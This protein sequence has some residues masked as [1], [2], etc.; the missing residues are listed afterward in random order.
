M[1]LMKTLWAVLILCLFFGSCK[2]QKKYMEKFYWSPTECSPE[3][4]PTNLVGGYF[5]FKDG[6]HIGMSGMDPIKNGWGRDGSNDAIGDG[7]NPIPVKLE[8]TWL[9][10][11]EN[12]FFSGSF[13][14]PSDTLL[15]LFQ[16]GYKDSHTL[17]QETYLGIDVGMAPG[18]VVVV[19]LQG[20]V[21]Q[22][23]IGRYQAK[24]LDLS[25]ADYISIK[26]Y[27]PY[28]TQDRAAL[29]KS[30]IENDTAVLENLAKKG[31]QFGLWD[32]YRKCFN[33]RPLMVYD[34]LNKIETSEIYMQFF[35][36]EK[37][38]L[39]EE[40]LQKNDY[41]SYARIKNIEVSF[42][43]DWAGKHQKYLAR[44]AFNEAEMFEVY[45]A[46]YG[47]NANEQAE[48]VLEVNGGND[49]YKI[50]LQSKDKKIEL[51]QQEGEILLDNL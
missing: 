47:S 8:I 11:T 41:S 44:I 43:E 51:V 6:S 39:I 28:T 17:K 22:K 48:L 2:S 7:K 21:Y 10:Y 18:G 49:H 9:S 3:L 46:I 24:E 14:L 25:M 15:N 19:W 35:N 26:G 34:N 42:T 37:D 32:S 40:R 12:K 50:F 33:M 38:D 29:C 30:M 5:I 20:S 4:Y 36:G 13:D 27:S 45:K 31:F 1:Q 16:L 23:E